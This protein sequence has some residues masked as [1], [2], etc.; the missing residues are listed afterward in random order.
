MERDWR[1]GL[2]RSWRV[3]ERLEG[4]GGAGG[5]ERDGGGVGGRGGGGERERGGEERR[6]RGRWREER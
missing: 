1:G 6:G 3:R 5:V 4:W 2:E